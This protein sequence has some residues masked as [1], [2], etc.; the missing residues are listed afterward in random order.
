MSDRSMLLQVAPQ[1]PCAEQQQQ[2]GQR[3]RRRVPQLLETGGP[4]HAAD[5][6]QSA[7]SERG[8]QHFFQQHERQRGTQTAQIDRGGD[9]LRRGEAGDS[10]KYEM[11]FKRDQEMTEFI[12]RFPDMRDKE[13]GEQ[14]PEHA[15]A[16]NEEHDGDRVQHEGDEQG[17]T[18]Q[19][20]PTPRPPKPNSNN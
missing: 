10:A 12:D 15:G 4:E 16:A 1:G 2:Q 19:G 11:L 3:D 7:P 5:Q 17:Q 14:R 6:E 13:V 9:G 8:C 18:A 20:G